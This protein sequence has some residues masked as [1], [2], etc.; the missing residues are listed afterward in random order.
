M[1]RRI[2]TLQR[3][4]RREYGE[5]APDGKTI[6]AWCE[7]FLAAGS[8]KKESGENIEEIRIEFQR[9]PQKSIHQVFR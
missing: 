3:N 8:V 4:Y 6:M 5:N 9:S 2:I 1:Q 7:M